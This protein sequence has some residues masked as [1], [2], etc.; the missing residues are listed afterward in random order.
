V[1]GSRFDWS[2]LYHGARFLAP[3]SEEALLLAGRAAGLKE[4]ATLLELACGNGAAAVFLAEE[5]HIYVRGVEG[6][7]DLLAEARRHAERSAA[8]PR[9]RFFHGDPLHP[10]AGLGPV[11]F[12][13]A[14]RGPA[15]VEAGLLG[16]GGRV[17]AGRFF[18]RRSPTPESAAEILDL[19]DTHAAPP[20]RVLWRREA[21][22]LEWERYL[23]PQERALRA[24]RARLPAGVAPSPVAVAAERQL[25]AFRAHGSYLA[26]EI[27]VVQP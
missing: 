17:L 14:F 4:G 27:A 7:A 19:F 18:A 8:G 16:R 25:A 13:C 9:I 23:R 20:G 15:G 6:R 24:Y 10:E 1:P 22:P 12:V 5:F 11:D 21:T 3:L 26:Y 2:D